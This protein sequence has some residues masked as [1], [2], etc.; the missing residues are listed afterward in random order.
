MHVARA[1]DAALT[2]KWKKMQEDGEADSMLESPEGV[3]I[4]FLDGEEAFASWTDTDST[5]GS[6]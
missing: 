4:L 3:Q 2:E 5:Y 1:I 6:R